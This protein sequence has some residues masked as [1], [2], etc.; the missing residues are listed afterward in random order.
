MTVF[1]LVS[2]VKR[3]PQQSSVHDDTLEDVEHDEGGAGQPL[4]GLVRH[5]LGLVPFNLKQFRNIIWVL[6]LFS[7]SDLVWLHGEVLD[8]LGVEERVHAGGSLL[9]VRG[10]HGPPELGAP[11]RDEDGARQVHAHRHDDNQPEP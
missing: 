2:T 11:L 7:L 6:I 10:V 4:L 5:D 1:Y 3:Y 9:V 8:G